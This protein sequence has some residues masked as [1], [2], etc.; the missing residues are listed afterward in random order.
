MSCI[1][2]LDIIRVVF[3]DPKSFLSILASA[4]YAA[5]VHPKII[6]TLLANG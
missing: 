5:A 4:A 1:S 6:K 2:L 3:P